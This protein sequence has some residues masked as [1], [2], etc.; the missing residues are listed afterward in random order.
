MLCFSC[1]FFHSIY[2][3]VFALY[4]CTL[5]LYCTVLFLL[6]VLPSLLLFCHLLLLHVGYLIAGVFLK[7]AEEEAIGS[8]V[9]Q[10]SEPPIHEEP[11]S[12]QKSIAL[13]VFAA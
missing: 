12:W 3:S 6:S 11:C 4:I 7:E 9:P 10:T 8:R 2:S 13:I 1:S 5:K